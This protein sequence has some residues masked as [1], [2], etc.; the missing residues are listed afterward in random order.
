MLDS[1][2][3]MKIAIQEDM[4]PGP[5]L[6]DRFHQAGDLG[7]Q[8]IEFWSQSLPGQAAEI[9]KLNG[10]G[11]VTAASI[12][13]GMRSR[14]LDPD[15]A[16]RKRAEQEL[17]EALTLA[18][19]IGASGVVFVPHFFSPLLPDLSPWKDAV[20]VERELL[21]TQLADLAE[22]AKQAGVELWVEPVNRYET[23]LLNHLGEAASL[24]A[25]LD[26]PNLGIVADLFHM[27]LEESDIPAVIREHAALIA[28]VHLA[29]TNRQLP[30][31][32][33]TNFTNA[34]HALADIN[35]CGWMAL[36]CESP[37]NNQVHARDLYAGLRDSLVFI[38]SCMK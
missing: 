34:F 14:F 11:G 12:N 35:F 22:H 10:T 36:E 3:S 5:T 23:H 17:K 21:R 6:A 30:G 18:G 32:G 2:H 15:P 7:L 31:R 26:H 24:L 28:H 4:L 27:A 19:R 29:D 13:N 37:G 33:T 38:R 1:H 9:E 16:E 25:P 20:A 8:G